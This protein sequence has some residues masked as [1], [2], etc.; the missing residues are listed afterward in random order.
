MN[1]KI[2]KTP[3]NSLQFQVKQLKINKRTRIF[4]SIVLTS[5]FITKKNFTFILQ[6]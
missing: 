6:I 1:N 5:I 2:K 4:K 3:L